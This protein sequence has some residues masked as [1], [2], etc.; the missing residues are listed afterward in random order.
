MT[1]VVELRKMQ[2]KDDITLAMYK[3]I[4]DDFYNAYFNSVHERHKLS[5]NAMREIRSFEFTGGS[6]TSLY[7]RTLLYPRTTVTTTFV[8]HLFHTLTAIGISNKELLNVLIS[9]TQRYNFEFYMTH[10][11]FRTKN[12]KELVFL[13][14]Y[15]KIYLRHFKEKDS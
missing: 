11:S 8:L 6:H 12:T 4:L 10:E 5:H 9:I 14:G 7:A 1:Y 2:R 3:N 15:K 13:V